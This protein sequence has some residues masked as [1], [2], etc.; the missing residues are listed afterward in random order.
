[1]F[2]VKFELT[3]KTDLD[4]KNIIIWNHSVWTYINKF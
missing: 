4:I 1:M 3:F 2:S